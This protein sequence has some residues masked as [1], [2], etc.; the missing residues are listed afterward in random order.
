LTVNTEIKLILKKHNESVN[1]VAEE[2]GMFRY[3]IIKAFLLSLL[4]IITII[5]SLSGQTNY[6]G[7]NLFV[8]EDGGQTWAVV[9]GRP[10]GLIPQRAVMAGDGT[11]YITYADGAGPHG[12]WAVP[13]PFE[14]GAV[15][16][17]DTSTN[18]WTNITPSGYTRP[19]G[20]ISVDPNNSKRIVASTNNTW[21]NQ[22]GGAWG[23]RFFIS[24]NGGDTWRDLGTITRDPNGVPW[25]QGHAIHWAGSIEFDP[26]NTSRV[27]VTSG[28]GIFT[29]EDIDAPS[30]TWKFT[31]KGL[32][33]T[34][35]LNLI[36]IPD[37]PMISVIGDYDGFVHHDVKVY[38][39]IHTPQMGTSNGLAY[40]A[41]QTNL[42]VR[43][44]SRLYR[45]DNTGSTWTLVNRPNT[46]LTQGNPALSADGNVL[47]WS[48]EN[49]NTT[50]RTTDWGQNWTSVTGVTDN[51]A[52][53]VADPLNPNVF[54]IYNPASGGRIL[55]STD[56]G[57]SF[58]EAGT[59]GGGGSRIIRTAPGREGDIWVARLTNGLWRSTDSGATFNP[60]EGVTGARAVGFG[61]EAPD[62]AYPAVYIWGTVD[63]V[64]GIFR[65]IDEGETWKR[66]ND[67]NHQYGGPGN[68]QIVMGDANIHGRV[69]M[70]TVGRGIVYGDRTENDEYTWDIVAIGGG[71]YVTAV[72]TSPEE[73]NL[74]YARTDVGGAYRWNE[75]EQVWIP[76]NDWIPESQVGLMG[77]ESLAIDPQHPNRVYMLAGTSYWS[78]GFTG[79]LRSD[80]YGDTFDVINVTGQ[81]RAHGNG[82]GRQNGE[83]LA[84]DPN[85]SDVLWVGTRSR[86]LFRSTDRGDTWERITS[87]NVTTTPNENGIC[88]VVLD[89]ASVENGNTQK[90]YVG[91]S[92]FT[93]PTNVGK[94]DDVITGYELGQNYPNPFNPETR[95]IYTL[96]QES[97]VTL[98]IYN[99]LGREVAA[100]VDTEQRHAGRHEVVFD[101]SNL[102]SGVYYYTIRTERYLE[103]KKMVLVR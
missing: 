62:A 79:I 76:L 37:G 66:I 32:E 85:N 6:S 14:R 67:D 8:S 93:D 42:V 97:T 78:N 38:S 5:G 23:D 90:I 94:R 65:S 25:I 16:R 96:P 47:L 98:Q 61:K 60:I 24:E 46:S 81:F 50:Y 12:H 40:A 64:T 17:L 77:I 54:Y 91:V 102:P 82:M 2:F 1:K 4:C 39:Q 19:F 44:G 57:E 26:F 71:G 48:P 55:I 101:A 99:L 56:A 100:L 103:T 13:E 75:D 7:D 30:T 87:L 31:V 51:S 69:Y 92:T 34:V 18:T 88:F 28:N 45:S 41:Q 73:E 35:P 63:G 36:S 58:E 68:A 52:R 72:I 49:S 10:T 22:G 33:E 20:G 29:T 21:L 70:T 80:D 43:A 9:E 89:K 83:R 27:F 86:G 3:K 59:P 84:V 74:I 53:P 11:L 15:W 95:V